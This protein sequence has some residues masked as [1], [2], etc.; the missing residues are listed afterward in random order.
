MLAFTVERVIQMTME[1]PTPEERRRSRKI[2]R[3]LDRTAKDL[4]YENADAWIQ[5]TARKALDETAR[6]DGYATFADRQNKEREAFEANERERLRYD[7]SR[8][9]SFRSVP[10]LNP[11]DSTRIKEILQ[12]LIEKTDS[13]SDAAKEIIFDVCVYFPRMWTFA[14]HWSRR[15]R[16]GELSSWL[17]RN[18]ASYL[19]WAKTRVDSIVWP[20][21]GKRPHQ[22]MEFRGRRQYLSPHTFIDEV[23]A[24][25]QRQKLFMEKANELRNKPTKAEEALWQ[26]LQTRPLGF[27][28][29]RQQPLLSRL[30]LQGFE[31][32]R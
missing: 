30:L 4:G 17:Q 10:D 11:K 23:A 25:K 31:A 15:F 20:E 19:R 24:K 14:L 16:K 21:E 22:Y 29:R 8:R 2:A 5:E 9:V 7:I 12:N 26:I 18:Y 1:K 3:S 32:S 27:H 13:D 28:F 6:M